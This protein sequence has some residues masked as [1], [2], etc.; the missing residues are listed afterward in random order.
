MLRI[1][2]FKYEEVCVEELI[3]KLIEFRAERDWEQF[4][5]PKD[6]SISIAIEAAELMEEFQWKNKE[7][8]AQHLKDNK[9]RVSDEIADIMTYLLLISHDLDIDIEA[10]IESKMIKNAKKYPVGRC[11]GKSL[12]YTDYQ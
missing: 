12:K 7:E 5:N 4:H 11:K 9:E 6:L 2:I 3:K 8:V 10:A 1:E